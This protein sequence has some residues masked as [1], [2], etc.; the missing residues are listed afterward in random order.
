MG[1]GI[2]LYL[3]HR[4]AGREVK[5]EEERREPE[6]RCELCLGEIPS[7]GEALQIHGPE[8]SVTGLMHFICPPMGEPLPLGD[9]GEA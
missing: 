4:E 7:I 3:T 6:L 2:F 5:K 8:G 1:V 9:Q